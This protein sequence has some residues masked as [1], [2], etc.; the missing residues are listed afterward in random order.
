MK[1]QNLRTNSQ[2]RRLF[3]LFSSLGI[4]DDM[5]GELVYNYTNGRTTH[6]SEL[7]YIEAQGLIRN[8]ENQQKEQMRDLSLDTKR[9][10]VIKAIFKWYEN[11]GK[12]VSMD[13]V[14]ATACRAAGGVEKF[15]N[16][17]AGALSRIYAE[18]CRKQQVQETMFN[19]PKSSEF[20]L[21]EYISNININNIK[22]LA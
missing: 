13:Y 15:N 9:K 19:P 11:Q 14:K 17:S 4:D 6:S 22:N 3:G 7:S 16:I 18:F 5:R 10:G 20:I 8:L 1:T 12:Q 2:N 21:E